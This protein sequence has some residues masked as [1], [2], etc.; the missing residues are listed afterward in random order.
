[1]KRS[2]S[3]G[4]KSPIGAIGEAQ[5]KYSASQAM[6]W[7]ELK[8]GVFS[9][10]LYQDENRS[11][12]TLLVRLEPEARSAP[13]SHDEFE[14]IY[15]IEGGF[16]DGERVLNAGDF[17]CRSPGQVHTAYSPDGALVLVT[18]TAA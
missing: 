10:L 17:C 15:V 13:H 2:A 9:K 1:M 12:R 4:E 6:P 16:E 8:P 5:S 14:Q 11:E 18:Y 7:E 3:I